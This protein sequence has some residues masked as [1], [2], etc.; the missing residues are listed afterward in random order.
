MS[1]ASKP[2]P[3]PKMV[4]HIVTQE[5]LDNN[6]DLATKGVKIGDEIEVPEVV[7][8]N[9]QSEK[10]EA[11]KEKMQPYLKAYPNNKKFF[12]A[13]DGQVFLEANE[14]SAKEHQKFIDNNVEVDVFEAK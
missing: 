14:D 13:S 5:D 3:Q 11:L 8:D 1:K 6:P 12:I 2:K 7:T 9:K 10:V 4:K